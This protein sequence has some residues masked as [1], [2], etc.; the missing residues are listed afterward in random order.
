[1]I[2]FTAVTGVV[3]RNETRRAAENLR[4]LTGEELK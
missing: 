3:E 2:S 1:M 4:K